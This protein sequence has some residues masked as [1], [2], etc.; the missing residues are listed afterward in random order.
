[1]KNR[2]ETYREATKK[3]S[4]KLKESGL[5]T[6]NTYINKEDKDLL[7]RVQKENKYR[8]LGDAIS[9]IIHKEN[10]S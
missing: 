10:D 7:I 5:E 3:R 1:M 2:K 6:L 4:I 9:H 8:I